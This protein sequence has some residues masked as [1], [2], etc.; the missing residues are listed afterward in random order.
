MADPTSEL[1]RLAEEQGLLGKPVP[2]Y[3]ALCDAL[4]PDEASRDGFAAYLDRIRR[5]RPTSDPVQEAR[6]AVTIGEAR[7]RFMREVWGD[8]WA[9]DRSGEPPAFAEI[10]NSL[11]AFEEAVRRE[12][13]DRVAALIEALTSALGT[14]VIPIAVLLADKPIAE[15]APSTYEA[16]REAQNAI[17]AAAAALREVKE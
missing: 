17:L 8:E 2:D 12:E 4:F 13:R 3:V 1:R 15:I 6:D 14:A 7:D 5:Q 16:M 10:L 9:R 11:S